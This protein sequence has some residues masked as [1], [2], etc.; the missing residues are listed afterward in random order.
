MS[1]NRMIHFQHCKQALLCSSF[2]WTGALWVLTKI[3]LS[4]WK[5]V[6]CDGTSEVTCSALDHTCFLVS[7]KRLLLREQLREGL[8]WGERAEGGAFTP[9]TSMLGDHMEAKHTDVMWVKPKAAPMRAAF[10][11]KFPKLLTHRLQNCRTAYGKSSKIVAVWAASCIL[12]CTFLCLH[13]LL[14]LPW[15]VSLSS[16]PVTRKP[17]MTNISVA[18]NPH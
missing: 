3:T 8:R 12:P 7:K 9:H 2:R 16:V 5:A 4:K 17:C 10:Q 11:M 14:L 13:P 18:G 6:S 1:L 15:G